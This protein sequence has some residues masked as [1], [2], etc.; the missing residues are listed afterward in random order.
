MG[1]EKAASPHNCQPGS[2]EYFLLANLSKKL[3]Q[4]GFDDHFSRIC[5][6]DELEMYTAPDK[7]G[8]DPTKDLRQ[9]SVFS[10]LV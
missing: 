4:V 8:G 6:A 9:K 5:S 10:R 3:T 1:E 7:S 2:W